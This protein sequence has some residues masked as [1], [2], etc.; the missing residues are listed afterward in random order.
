MWHNY[1]KRPVVVQAVRLTEDNVR[2]IASQI[3][4]HLVHG[5]KGR[6]SEISGIAIQTLEGLMT[7]NIG[8]YVVSGVQ[9]ELYPVKP[10]IFNATY[11]EAS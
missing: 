1:T 8:D 9:D 5:G 10:D 4:A 7:A 3:G 6:R 2:D 11:E